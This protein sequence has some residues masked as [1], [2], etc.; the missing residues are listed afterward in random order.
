MDD[1]IWRKLTLRGVHVFAVCVFV[2]CKCIRLCICKDKWG[3]VNGGWLHF[4]DTFFWSGNVF[5]VCVI[6][7]CKCILCEFVKTNGVKWMGAAD[8]I[9]RKLTLF[10]SATSLLHLT[11]LNSCPP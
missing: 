2:K 11:W 4:E 3:K 8:Y 10:V 7:K 6:V 5:A 1:C 9:W